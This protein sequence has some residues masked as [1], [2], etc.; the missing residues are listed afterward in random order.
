LPLAGIAL[1]ILLLGLFAVSNASASE[2][3]GAAR[4]NDAGRVTGLLE[5]GAETNE[6]GEQAATALH[7]AAYH[8]NTG[9]VRVLLDAGA[10][11]DAV[12]ENGSTPL[13]LAAHRGH[14]EVVRVLLSQGGDPGA[15]N[16]EGV[17][18]IGWAR[19][20]GRAATVRLLAAAKPA[21]ETKARASIS[22]PMQAT[23]A[24]KPS[25]PG[26]EAPRSASGGTFRVQLVAVSSEQRARQV[27]EDHRERFEDILQDVKLVFEP[28]AGARPG[29][30]RVQSVPLGPQ[31]AR[32]L[33]EQL[34]QRDQAC[35]LRKVAPP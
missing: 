26:P 20:N 5:A 6:R 8:G 11:V 9:L 33:C 7:W 32:N 3:V 21:S 12:L 2:L 24:S 22:T 14:T 13:H 10:E 19:R 18:P 4:L 15:R 29:L 34:K 27:V 31:R 23:T 35:L 25:R 28:V 16:L 17:T 1:L 30:F